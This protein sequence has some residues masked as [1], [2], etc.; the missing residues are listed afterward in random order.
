MVF[1]TGSFAFTSVEN[2]FLLRGFGRGDLHRSA[3]W[4]E[5]PA[6]GDAPLAGEASAATLVVCSQSE[7]VATGYTNSL[8]QGAAARGA[9]EPGPARSGRR[10]VA[11][12]TA[13]EWG[14]R[15]S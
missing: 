3:E 8:H 4:G 15:H 6:S 2:D 10:F 12:H 14:V 5:D 11:P 1:I 9:A 7:R 13:F